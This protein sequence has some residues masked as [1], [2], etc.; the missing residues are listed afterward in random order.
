MCEYNP[1]Y[2][3]LVLGR[4]GTFVQQICFTENVHI[5]PLQQKLIK[6]VYKAMEE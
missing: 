3:L 4:M 2:K 5:T 6:F 1:K